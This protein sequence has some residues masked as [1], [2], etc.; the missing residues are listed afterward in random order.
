MLLPARDVDKPAPTV[1]V[2]GYQRP[3]GNAPEILA[4]P[5]N[6]LDEVVFKRPDGGDDKALVVE[7][8]AVIVDISPEPDECEAG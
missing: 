4:S 3:S 1:A 6:G 8:D 7:A 5:L 2:A